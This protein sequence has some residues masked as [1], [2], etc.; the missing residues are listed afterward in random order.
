MTTQELIAISLSHST[1]VIDS[2][3][4]VDAMFLSYHAN[5]LQQILHGAEII[6][7]IQGDETDYLKRKS[8]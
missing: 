1:I 3:S 4:Y 5:L 6:I 8:C 7:K 2:P